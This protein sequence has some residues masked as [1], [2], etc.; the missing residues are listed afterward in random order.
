MNTDA[1][2]LNKILAYRI[3]RHIKKIIHCNQVGSIPGMQRWYNIFKSI[4]IIQHINRVKDKN[5][6]VISIEAE[7]AFD[8]TQYPFMINAWK[9]LGLEGTLLNIIKSH[10]EGESMILLVV[11]LSVQQ[12]GGREKENDRI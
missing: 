6:I 12:G 1:K 9:K 4:N 11:C 10:R 5:H 3:Q 7:K 8:K 2:I